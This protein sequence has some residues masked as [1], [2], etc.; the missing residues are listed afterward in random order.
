[1]RE[2]LTELAGRIKEHKIE[3]SLEMFNL[4][5]PEIAKACEL[6]VP[7]LM[8]DFLASNP[9]LLNQAALSEW[10]SQKDRQRGP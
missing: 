4:A 8:F 10:A 7:G 9:E 1:V 2:L 3:S 5:K 6:L